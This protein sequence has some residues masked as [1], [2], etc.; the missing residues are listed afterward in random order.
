MKTNIHDYIAKSAAMEWAPLVEPV[1][2]TA[3]IFVKPLR[4]DEKQGRAPAILLRFEAGA[5]YPYHNHPG[6]EELF[7]LQGSA[8][9]EGATLHAGDYLYTPP[10]LKHAVTTQTG[11]VLL[12]SIPAEVEI[13]E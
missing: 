3:G 11:C 13:L 4:R 2:S 10:G 5:R 8:I 7:V 12:L 6:G 9:I 1:I